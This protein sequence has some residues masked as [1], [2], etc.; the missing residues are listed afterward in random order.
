METVNNHSDNVYDDKNARRLATEETRRLALEKIEAERLAQ[1]RERSKRKKTPPKSELNEEE[2][3]NTVR[4][5]RAKRVTISRHDYIKRMVAIAT[6]SATVALSALGISK[7]AIEEYNEVVYISKY[8]NTF[9]REV[10]MPERHPTEDHLN[11]FYDYSDIGDKI[12]ESDNIDEAVFCMLRAI[13]EYQT[14]RVLGTTDYKSLSTFITMRGYSDV[15]DFK[16]QATYMI[17]LD[18]EI[19]E[20][21]QEL[22]QIIQKHD[23]SQNESTY[24]S[25]RGGK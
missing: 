21:Q 16:K 8:V 23:E 25:G 14:N 5:S 13:G 4:R 20:K 7:R 9:K 6:A 18:K 11:Y 2:S 10:I 24:P 12:E 22:D 1:A 3:A 19:E 15:D 17:M